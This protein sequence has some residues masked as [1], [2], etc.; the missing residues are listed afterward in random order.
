MDRP[1]AAYTGDQPYIFRRTLERAIY[2]PLTFEVA[3]VDGDLVKARSTAERLAE[4]AY[5]GM[6]GILYLRLGDTRAQAQ[7]TLAAE[8]PYFERFPWFQNTVH[9]TPELREHPLILKVN[10]ALGFTKAW[11][12][13]L[14]KRASTLP[15]ESHITC[16]PSKYAL[17]DS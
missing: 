8:S 3:M 17:T 16:D 5:H 4:D 2:Y 14:C 6:A 1:F 12:L 10:D 13:E 7:L 11:R 15:P 9:L